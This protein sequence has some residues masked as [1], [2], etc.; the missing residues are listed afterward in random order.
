VPQ[1]NLKPFNLEWLPSAWP[2]VE[3]AENTCML[4]SLYIVQLVFETGVILGPKAKNTHPF[5]DLLPPE[6]PLEVPHLQKHLQDG[7]AIPCKLSS[8]C[9]SQWSL[10]SERDL[11]RPV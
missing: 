1:E 9:V 10:S 2:S 11:C 6:S 8:A 4:R 7:H 3:A 5:W